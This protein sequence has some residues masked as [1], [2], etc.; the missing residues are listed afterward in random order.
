MTVSESQ[1]C[2]CYC[3][4]KTDNY[5]N[6]YQF[7]FESYCRCCLSRQNISGSSSCYCSVNDGSHYNS[8]CMCNENITNR[9][10][11]CNFTCTPSK[12][13]SSQTKDVSTLQ[14]MPVSI[15]MINSTSSKLIS[16]SEIVAQH[17]VSVSL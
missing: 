6:T 16:T 4:E 7:E 9:M 3:G 15:I 1:T 17:I 12:L 5:C 11:T 14:S 2:C 8:K 10:L 13:S